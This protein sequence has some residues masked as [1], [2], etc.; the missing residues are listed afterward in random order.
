MLENRTT[1]RAADQ[2]ARK[3]V[4][5]PPRPA[6]ARIFA[7]YKNMKPKAARLLFTGADKVCQTKF[8]SLRIVPG[9][10]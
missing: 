4:R 9:L 3:S 8:K 10:T 2:F 5:K 7:E 6:I 1:A